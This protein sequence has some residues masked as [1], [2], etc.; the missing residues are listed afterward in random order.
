MSI[1]TSIGHPEMDYAEHNRTYAGFLT[2]AKAA[3]GAMVVL[4]VGMFVFLV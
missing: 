2:L 1:E 4:L 3:I